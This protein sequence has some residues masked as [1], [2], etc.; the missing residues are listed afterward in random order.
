M[1]LNDW[2][3]CRQDTAGRCKQAMNDCC[4]GAVCVAAGVVIGS[5][6]GASSFF[7]LD[8]VWPTQENALVAVESHG[9]VE[10]EPSGHQ[11]L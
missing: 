3:L 4:R 11:N 2:A 1:P 7:L 5:V 8:A 9:F 6:L 10:Q